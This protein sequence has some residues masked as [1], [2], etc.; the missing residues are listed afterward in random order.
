[1]RFLRLL[2]FLLVLAMSSNAQVTVNNGVDRPK[3]VVG[4]VIDQMRWIIFTGTATGMATMGC[5]SYP[6]DS[7][8]TRHISLTRLQ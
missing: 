6:K 2:L 8:T 1:M 5:A 4:L 3:L 7:V